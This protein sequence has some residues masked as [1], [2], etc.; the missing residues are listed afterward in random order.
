LDIAGYKEKREKT[1]QDLA[2]KIEKTVIR[3]KKQLVLEPMTAYERK[4][5]HTELQ[6]SQQV[7]TLSRGEEPYRKVVVTLK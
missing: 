4:I 7:K 1:L 6:N 5:I 3:T 2:H